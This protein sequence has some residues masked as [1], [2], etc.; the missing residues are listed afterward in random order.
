MFDTSKIEINAA[1]YE[2]FENVFHEDFFSILTKM[3]PSNRIKAL[4]E[5]ATVLVNENG[6]E[7]KIQDM[8]KLDEDEQNELMAYN[9]K[10]GGITKKYTSRIAYIGKLLYDKKYSG[11][12]EG[13][14]VFLT[15]YDA[16][17][18]MNPTTSSEIWEK[19][20]KDQAVPLSAKNA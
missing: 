6:E 4:K 20:M 14:M 10:V 9:I 12:Y 3:R 13:F 8:S 7:K 16:S 18:F 17:D 15:S 11:S 1:F 5:R 19:I 2:L